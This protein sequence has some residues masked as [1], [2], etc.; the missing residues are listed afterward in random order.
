MG[1]PSDAFFLSRHQATLP[2]GPKSCPMKP[3]ESL[4]PYWMLLQVAKAGSI[5]EAARELNLKPPSVATQMKALEAQYGKLFSSDRLGIHF[6]E[7]GQEVLNTAQILV[8]A[9]ERLQQG[10]TS[11]TLQGVILLG[12]TSLA[13]TY[14]LPRRLAA[15][16]ALHPRVRIHLV[17]SPGLACQQG[18]LHGSLSLAVAG[19]TLISQPHL[20]IEKASW[21]KDRL[22][23]YAHPQARIL[24]QSLSWP[25]RLAASQLLFRESGSG[26]RDVSE[27]LLRPWLPSFGGIQEIRGAETLR[28]CVIAG[29]G[30]GVLSEAAVE[31]EVQQG[32]LLPVELP[33][34]E[35]V[36]ALFLI[37]KHSPSHPPLYAALW[38]FLLRESEG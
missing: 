10:E 21:R 25:E 30:A 1:V 14:L 20:S 36:R 15:F 6:T 37:R 34:C 13:A 7:R 3:N 27:P 19:E 22:R 24:D 31:R 28:E 29:L 11:P 35:K 8:S 23:L 18:V 38:D 12:A 17:V 5:T 33:N 16:Q 9:L 4:Y 32:L 26:V 2:T